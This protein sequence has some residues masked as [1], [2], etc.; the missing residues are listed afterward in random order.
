MQ[1]NVTL[2]I[3]QSLRR[4]P[5]REVYRRREITARSAQFLVRL[6]SK[7]PITLFLSLSLWIPQL[8][9]RRN[10]CWYRWRWSPYRCQRRYY[11]LIR[12]SGDLDV[13]GRRCDPG[14]R[15]VHHRGGLHHWSRVQH[16]N[17]PR[18]RDLNASIKQYSHTIQIDR[19]NVLREAT[20][21]PSTFHSYS[22]AR[23]T[24]RTDK[25]R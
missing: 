19:P 9:T 5:K 14:Q 8:C 1:R 18:L 13:F 25:D 15:V 10:R 22:V 11:L 3:G 2:E 23:G 4:K 12:R 7:S 21:P 20:F 24:A 17:H 6:S 16:G